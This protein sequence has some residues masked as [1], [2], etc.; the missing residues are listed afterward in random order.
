MPVS[1]KTPGYQQDLALI[2]SG[3]LYNTEE[4]YLLRPKGKV[5]LDASYLVSILGGLYGRVNPEQALRMMKRELLPLDVGIL[6]G[7]T[8][9]QG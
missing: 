4:E 3:A 2:A 9:V 8:V 5:L 6:Q 1:E 7:N